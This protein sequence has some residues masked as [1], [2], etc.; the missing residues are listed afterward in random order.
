MRQ[1]SW[2]AM[3]VIELPT[4]NIGQCSRTFKMVFD[5]FYPQSCGEVWHF[6]E[7]FSSISWKNSCETLCIG[8]GL[9]LKDSLIR[10]PSLKRISFE[11]LQ[12][13]R[14]RQEIEKISKLFS[15]SSSLPS[16]CVL[17]LNLW[18]CFYTSFRPFF[19][20]SSFYFVL[21][22]FIIYLGLLS[23]VTLL[24]CCVIVSFNF[25]YFTLLFSIFSSCFVYWILPFFQLFRWFCQLSVV[26]LLF[27]LSFLYFFY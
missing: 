10:C 5:S 27:Y 17:C 14:N 22:L 26:C 12:I 6:A 8:F 11:Y 9:K 7:H 23:L 16:F 21:L 1:D 3:T 15:P 19:I 2:C 20:Q 4:S 25:V 18:N 24:R 13:L